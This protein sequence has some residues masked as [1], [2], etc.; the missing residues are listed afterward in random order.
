[1]RVENWPSIMRRAIAAHARQ[2][3]V[4][5]ASD[6]SFVFD[7]IRD[8][9]GRDPIAEIRGYSSELGA[10]RALRAAG[11]ATTLDLI[12]R[13]FVEIPPATAQRGDIG[14]PS[15]IAHPLMSPAIID[16]ANC[17]SKEPRGAVVFPRNHIARAWRV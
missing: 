10:L 2:P 3:F 9:T 17:Y 16:G 15:N 11:Y 8:M 14:Y 13:N 6:C 4:W 5:G 7:I 1:M 12:E